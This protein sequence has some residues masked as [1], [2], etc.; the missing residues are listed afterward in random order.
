MP[1]TLPSDEPA[2]EPDQ[3]ESESKN[4]AEGSHLA[5]SG[6]GC[7]RFHRFSLWS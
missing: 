3:H 4:H 2:I 1:G 5:V 6:L 7:W